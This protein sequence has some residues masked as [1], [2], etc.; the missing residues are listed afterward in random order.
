VWLRRARRK[1]EARR[2]LQPALEVF[3]RLGARPWA[4]RTRAEMEATGLPAPE[5]ARSSAALLTPQELQ[6]A[7]LAGQGLSNKD[8]AGQLFLSPKT[9]AYHLYK[10]YPKLGVAG[11]GDLARLAL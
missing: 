4:A 6:I 10:A 5:P 7:R 11:R 9:V 1:A 2:V 8:I 3:D